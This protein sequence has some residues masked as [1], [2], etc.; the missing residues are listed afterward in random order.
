MGHVATP[1]SRADVSLL[2]EQIQKQAVLPL[3]S[4]LPLPAAAYWDESFYQLEL[5][6]IFRKD[7]VCIARAEEVPDPGSYYAVDLAG[8]PLMVVRGADNEIRVLSRV[9]R[10]RYEDLLGGETPPEARLKG[11]AQRFECPYHAWIYRTD[12]SLLSA[13]EM[14]ARAD[15]DKSAFGLRR[16]R[17]QIWQGFIFVNLDDDGDDSLD[18]TG[19]EEIQEAY[20]FTN[21]RLTG[22]VDWGETRVNWKIVLENFLECYHHIGIH[23]NVLQPLWRLGKVER[24]SYTGHDWYY[25]RMKA[26]PDTAIGEEDGHLQLPL[27][28]PAAPGLSAYQRS[29]TLLFAKFPCFMLAPG[30][31][32]AFW[33]RSFP[34]G[35]ETHR[36]DINFLVPETSLTDGNFDQGMQEATDFLRLVQGQDASVNEA[37]QSSAKSQYAADGVLSLHEQPLWQ[38][39]KYL[40]SRL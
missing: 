3:E 4:A 17:S 9:C 31:D 33:F 32:I 28:L 36:L 24:G 21:W 6:R 39:Q 1:D 34:T 25:A 40:A 13:P 7:W 22:V 38:I 27:W 20:D 11:C 2:V 5:E 37:V 16:V 14:G 18:M 8:E 35:P 10:H 12:G 30:P 29:H 15:F 19:I 26:G 23:K